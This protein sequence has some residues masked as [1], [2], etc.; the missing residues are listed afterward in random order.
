MVVACAWMG[1]GCCLRMGSE[2][3]SVLS[4]SHRCHK[5]FLEMTL[6]WMRRWNKGGCSNCDSLRKISICICDT[7]KYRRCGCFLGCSRPCRRFTPTFLEPTSPLA[8]PYSKVLICCLDLATVGDQ[9]HGTTC[10]NRQPHPCQSGAS[11]P[12]IPHTSQCLHQ[13]F[14]RSHGRRLRVGDRPRHL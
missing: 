8:A 3:G 11:L 14:P 2:R 10:M 6:N 12:R 5:F 1:V 7:V 9:W 13:L 4:P